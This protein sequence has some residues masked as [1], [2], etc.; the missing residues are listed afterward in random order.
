LFVK[1]G[2]TEQR[3]YSLSRIFAPFTSSRELYGALQ[4]LKRIGQVINEDVG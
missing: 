1:L 4:V 3:Y 2:Q